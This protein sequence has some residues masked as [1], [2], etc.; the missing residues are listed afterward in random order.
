MLRITRDKT[1]FGNAPFI[2]FTVYRSPKNKTTVYGYHEFRYASGN[3]VRDD[4][5]PLGIPVGQAFETT[6]R[7]AEASGIAAIWV[8]DPD[9]LFDLEQSW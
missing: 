4:L 2:T 5:T 3:K 7:A 1:A 9:W 6:C 8:D